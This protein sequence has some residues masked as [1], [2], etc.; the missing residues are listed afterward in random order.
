MRRLKKWL[1]INL[2]VSGGMS[3]GIHV[4]SRG[5]PYHWITWFFIAM[6][7]TGLVF[8]YRRELKEL[9]GSGD[10]PSYKKGG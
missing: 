5:G 2:C 10:V 1:V 9:N 3:Y 7:I 8:W 4:A 6:V